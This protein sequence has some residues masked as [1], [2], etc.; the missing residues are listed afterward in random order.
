VAAAG[1]SGACRRDE[2]EI[3]IRGAMQ[4][5]GAFVQPAVVIAADQDE[6]VEVG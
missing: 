2:A 4:D 3:A 6:F 1:G 5:F